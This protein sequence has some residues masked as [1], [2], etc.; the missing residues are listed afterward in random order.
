MLDTIEII[1]RN[2]FSES[3]ITILLNGHIITCDNFFACSF[4]ITF[5]L[6]QREVKL[7]QLKLALF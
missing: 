5:L 3:F 2:N 1:Y 6:L 4:S 7:I